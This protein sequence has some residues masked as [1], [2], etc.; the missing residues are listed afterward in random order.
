[1]QNTFVSFFRFVEGSAGHLNGQPL[2]LEDAQH[3]KTEGENF[4]V[5]RQCPNTKRRTQHGF[6]GLEF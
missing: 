4:F 5:H 2:I 1:M 6:D 3:I